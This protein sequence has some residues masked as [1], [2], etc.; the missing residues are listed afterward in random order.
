MNI[1]E[2]NV[3]LAPLPIIN[4]PTAV[5]VPAEVEIAENPVPLSDNPK[6][7]AADNTLRYLLIA[8]LC[9]AFAGTFWQ[10]EER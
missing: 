7:G 8:L 1:T 9:L 5:D 4:E 10:K 2:P 6:T 3:P